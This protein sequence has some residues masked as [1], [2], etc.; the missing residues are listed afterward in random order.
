MDAKALQTVAAFIKRAT[1]TARPAVRIIARHVP[2]D[3]RDAKGAS[4]LEVDLRDPTGKAFYPEDEIARELVDACERDAD[5]LNKGDQQYVLNS[6]RE[7]ETRP[8]GRLVLNV[9]GSSDWEDEGDRSMKGTD[10][11]TAEGL[12]RQQMTFSKMLVERAIQN[13]GHVIIQA[14]NDH[15]AREATKLANLYA[16]NEKL[17]RE[18]TDLTTRNRLLDLAESTDRAKLQQ[19]GELWRYAGLAFPYLLHRLSGGQ[20]QPPPE[21]MRLASP[22]GAMEEGITHQLRP[23][24]APASNVDVDELA[25]KMT[26]A[27]RVTFLENSGRLVDAFE[28]NPVAQPPP[29]DAPPATNGATSHEKPTPTKQKN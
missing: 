4:V 21:M 15:I 5:S 8:L 19:R 3:G 14:L 25:R 6:F 2:A 26:D 17:R 9:A 28:R 16:D 12:L 22:A 7:G 11:P 27:D 10:A 29:V 1:G 24:A 23:A 20:G 18:L 13:D